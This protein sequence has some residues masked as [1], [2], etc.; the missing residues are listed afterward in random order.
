M[1][2][3]SNPVSVPPDAS[4]LLS[5]LIDLSNDDDD[6]EADDD[7]SNEIVTAVSVHS[8]SSRDSEFND[9]NPDN[10]DDRG[11]LVDI[12]ESRTPSPLPAD[13]AAVVVADSDLATVPTETDNENLPVSIPNTANT[14]IQHVL[15]AINLDNSLSCFKTT[16]RKKQVVSPPVRKDDDVDEAEV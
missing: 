7:G 10:D 3:D 15:P 8:V 2:T 1:A 4:A 5:N 11:S 9:E 16:K 12:Y 13:T 6:D 14:V